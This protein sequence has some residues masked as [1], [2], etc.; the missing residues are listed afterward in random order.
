MNIGLDIF[1]FDKP[2]ANYGVGRGVYVWHLLP[3]LFKQGKEHHFFIFANKE[4]C[5]LITNYDNVTIIVSCLPNRVRVLRI[6]HEQFYLPYQF[7]INKLDIIHFLGNNI[8]HSLKKKSVLTVY[9]LM[10]KYYL[11]RGERSLKYYYF[12]LTVPRSIKLS[13]TI[14]TISRFVADQIR[15]EFKKNAGIYPILL[16]PCDLPPVSDNAKQLMNKKYD[17]H[18]IYTVTTSMQHKNLITLLK[19]FAILKETK[20][21]SGKLI[22][23]GQLKGD[24]HKNT[25]SYVENASLNEDV[26]LTDFVSEEEKSYLYRN[27]DMFVFPSLYEGFG[28][29]VLEAMSVGIPVI[30]SHAASLPEV[31][32][33]AC[34]YFN[35]DSVD[36]LAEK[37]CTF[38]NNHAECDRYK[39]K[40]IEH[41]KMFSWQQ[42]ARKT[43]SVYEKSAQR[44]RDA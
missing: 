41:Y 14:I 7:I 44:L 27:A 15:T 25:I 34:I 16:A 40:G 38:I 42:V 1:S 29:P 18:Y 11:D 43:L 39:Q 33:E 22:I 12:M 31:G 4:N 8:S 20:K 13:Q 5:E 2:G 3:E 37:I 32:G 26:V 10:W 19:A 28:L 17:F 24:Y 23:S 9:D 6:L 36:E 35:P 30:A 21:Y